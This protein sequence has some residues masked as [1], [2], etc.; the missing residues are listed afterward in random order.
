MVSY[1]PV[2]YFTTILSIILFEAKPSKGVSS[3]STTIPAVPPPGITVDL[4]TRAFHN[5][6]TRGGGSVPST[7]VDFGDL[8]RSHKL[9]ILF[10]VPGAFTPTCSQSHLPGYVD[11]I[12]DLKAA[13]VEAV[14]CMSVNDAFVMQA[15]GDATPGCWGDH[16]GGGGGV[17]R[18]VADG[19]GE[20]TDA[21]GMAC[22]CA[23][24][25]MGKVRCKRF[26]AIVRDGKFVVVNVDEDEL[27]NTSVEAI[28]ALL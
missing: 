18:L 21:I 19:N 14:Y 11:R 7:D 23:G 22:D 26:A 27:V 3:M 1:V 9:A 25:R 28:L 4:L 16:G 13:G 15:W 24:W 6:C 5:T 12:S 8:L 17:I 20:A 2:L 10:G